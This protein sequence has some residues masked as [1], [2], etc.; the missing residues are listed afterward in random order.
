ML[1]KLSHFCDSTTDIV[2][3]YADDKA[4]LIDTTEKVQRIKDTFERFE[5][6]LELD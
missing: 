6:C 3:A 2:S 1:Q 4:I 5:R